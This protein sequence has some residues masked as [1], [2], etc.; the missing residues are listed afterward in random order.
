LSYQ[1]GTESY[2]GYDYESWHYRYVGKDTAK[3][4]YESNLTPN[5]YLKLEQ[6]KEFLQDEKN[7]N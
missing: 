1:Q 6:F 2:T 4:M 3:S 5:Q 7:T